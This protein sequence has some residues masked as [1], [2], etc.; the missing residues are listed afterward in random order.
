MN[1][2]LSNCASDA[3]CHPAFRCTSGAC[4]PAMPVTVTVSAEADAY[5]RDGGAAATN[6]GTD[7]ALLVKNSTT[8]GN[9]RI[10]YLRFPLGGVASVG[11]ARLRLYGSR[12]TASMLTDAAFS[13]PSNMWTETGITWNSRPMIGSKLGASVVVGATAQYYEWDVT[14]HVQAQKL[15]GASAVSVA[16][17]M[18]MATG[19]SPDGFNAKEAGANT[20]QLVVVP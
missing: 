13:V 19:N 6:F 11:Q 2:C 18:E 1:A 4:T 17:Q 3:D 15:A 20:P 9:H 7:P 12:A 10:S 8:A 5:V 14:A 16:I